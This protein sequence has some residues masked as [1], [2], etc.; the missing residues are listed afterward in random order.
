MSEPKR[1]GCDLYI[2]ATAALDEEIA[3]ELEKEETDEAK[4]SVD[5]SIKELI[6]EAR[7]KTGSD[8]ERLP[9]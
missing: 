5:K 3:K 7:A 6:D 1:V 8:G 9:E 2:Q 4:A